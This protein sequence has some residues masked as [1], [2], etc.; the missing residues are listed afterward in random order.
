MVDCY[1]KKQISINILQKCEVLILYGKYNN[2]EA[3]KTHFDE[4]L[5]IGIFKPQLNDR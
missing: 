5:L 2:S 3:R 4:D 1:I